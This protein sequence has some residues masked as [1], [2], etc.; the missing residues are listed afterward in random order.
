MLFLDFNREKCPQC[1][2]TTYVLCITSEIFDFAR[3]I[4]IL[5]TIISSILL[6]SNWY[7]RFLLSD[8]Y[9]YLT[10]QVNIGI[11]GM[12]ADQRPRISAENT[13]QE[14]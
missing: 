12:Y 6:A 4:N 3:I 9:N 10:P 7:K 1:I 8:I 14:L 11:S 5:G 2:K 13:R